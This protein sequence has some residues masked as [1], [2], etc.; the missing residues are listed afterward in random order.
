MAP[1]IYLSSPLY[2]FLS[3]LSQNTVS[4]VIMNSPGM[5]SPRLVFAGAGFD[6]TILH[7][8]ILSHSQLFRTKALKRSQWVSVTV[9]DEL[10]CHDDISDIFKWRS[11]FNMRSNSRSGTAGLSLPGDSQG[12]ELGLTFSIFVHITCCMLHVTKN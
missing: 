3:Y 8:K 6:S 11:R 9:R 7:R 10:I 4:H 5:Y 2:S 12:S 1:S